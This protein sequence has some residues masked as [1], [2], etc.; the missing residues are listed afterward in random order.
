MQS[1]R[2]Y[3][4]GLIMSTS[5]ISKE[6]IIWKWQRTDTSRALE[7]LANDGIIA[8]KHCEAEMMNTILKHIRNISIEMGKLPHSVMYLPTILCMKVWH[9]YMYKN[10]DFKVD[11][12]V[13]HL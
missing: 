7:A 2:P 8:N 6:L 5:G 1:A 10:G 4:W 3:I 12:E 13:E 9:T 11:I